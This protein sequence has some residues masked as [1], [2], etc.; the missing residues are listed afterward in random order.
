MNFNNLSRT[1]WLGCPKS[2]GQSLFASNIRHLTSKLRHVNQNSI[3][4]TKMVVEP[5]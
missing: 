5:T 3:L 1:I 4:P 2:D